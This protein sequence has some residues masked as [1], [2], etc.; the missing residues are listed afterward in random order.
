MLERVWKKREPSY[1]VVG[2]VNWYSCHGKQYS[3]LKK[4]KIELLCDLAVPLL[5]IHVEKTKF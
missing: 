2:Y 3:F 4:L 1:T 5:G